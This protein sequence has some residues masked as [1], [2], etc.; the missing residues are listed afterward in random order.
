MIMYA[1]VKS[2]SYIK[3]RYTLKT[4][5]DFLVINI[6]RQVRL[7]RKKKIIKIKEE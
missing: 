4:N 1:G 5:K 6:L 7:N 2:M 3:Y